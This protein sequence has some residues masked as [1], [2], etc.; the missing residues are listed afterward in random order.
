MGVYLCWGFSPVI[1]PTCTCHL[2][3]P[4]HLWQQWHV[5]WPCQSWR[6][7]DTVTSVSEILVVFHIPWMQKR[8]RQSVACTKKGLELMLQEKSWWKWR[9]AEETYAGIWGNPPLGR[10]RCCSWHHEIET[11]LENITVSR[12]VP[13]FAP[14]PF[15]FSGTRW[16]M[17]SQ[18][19]SA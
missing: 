14:R 16:C 7:E 5:A 19:G 8:G 15:S 13:R 2:L 4:S 12:M 6:S 17:R 1:D 18:S 9:Y 10:R 11:A 3:G